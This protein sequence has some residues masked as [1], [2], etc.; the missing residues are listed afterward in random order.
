MGPRLSG[1]TRAGESR[2]GRD[3]VRP[4]P[5]LVQVRND[6]V[7]VVLL[8]VF[9]IAR[10]EVIRIAELWPSATVSAWNAVIWCLVLTLPFAVRRRYP[11]SVLVFAM[12]VGVVATLRDPFVIMMFPFD[13][14]FYA[15]V[16]TASGWGR[17]RLQTNVVLATLIAYQVWSI[18]YRLSS[19]V[20]RATVGV[21]AEPGALPPMVGYS[22]FVIAVTG[23]YTVVVWVIGTLGWRHARR[24]E[25]LRMQTR[26]LREERSKTARRAVVADRLRIARELHD[27]VA[28][29]VSV[30]GIQ[31]AAARRTMPHDHITA[32][33]A[34]EEVE[35]SSH[36][37]VG[38][39][40]ALLGSLRVDAPHQESAPSA[41]HR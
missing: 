33:R 13:F 41:G 23:F 15:F 26:E 36:R 39:M 1:F 10:F 32:A 31:A 28:H 29:H 11:L 16:C 38:E 6:A 25:E 35:T 21:Q 30:I 27:V 19:P 4:H 24:G 40:D 18:A 2:L 14:F 12:I 34:L 22:F 20:V 5:D 37:V 7:A 3:W 9:C 17:S 8:I